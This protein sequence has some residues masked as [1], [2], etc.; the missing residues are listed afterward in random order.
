M[1]K[2]RMKETKTREE[3]LFLDHIAMEAD[4][5]TVR[6]RIGTLEQ[7]KELLEHWERQSHLRNLKK[8]ESTSY[9]DV[10]N[11]LDRNLP[12]LSPTKQTM[13][14]SSIGFDFRRK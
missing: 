11:Y 14:S 4:L 3:Q 6:D 13:Q 8:L 5:Q 9:G 1:T 12:D 7:Q 2:A 10:A